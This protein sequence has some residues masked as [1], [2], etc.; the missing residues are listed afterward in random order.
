M[1]DFLLGVPGKLKTVIDHLTTHL[2]STR[3]AKIDQLDAAISSRAAASTAL[4]T[5]TWT[6]ARAGYLDQINTG[7]TK[8]VKSIQT[9]FVTFEATTNGSGEIKRSADVTVSGVTI[10][11]CVILLEG[12][13]YNS[14][15]GL[16]LPTYQ[17]PCTAYL[18][19]TTNLKIG[20]PSSDSR[21]FRVRWTIVEF[22]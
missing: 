18:S 7:L 14:D 22:Y 20:S 10:A 4:S 15:P 5:A 12:G 21:F 16:G 13:A 8:V 11:R 17:N 3:A 9:G 19:S 1:I 2:S 6:S